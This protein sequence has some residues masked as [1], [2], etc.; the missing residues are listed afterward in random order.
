[1]LDDE[2]TVVMEQAAPGS[3]AVLHKDITRASRRG[4][5]TFGLAHN[6]VGGVISK[7]WGFDVKEVKA[8]KTKVMVS[9]NIGDTQTAPEETLPKNPHSEWLVEHFTKHAA[10]CQVN[11]GGGEGKPNQHG[12]QMY[13]MVNGEFVAQLAAL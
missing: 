7:N 5:N 8:E 6:A 12:A 4:L 1:M 11:V 13:K 2:E 10:A 3:S 9:Y